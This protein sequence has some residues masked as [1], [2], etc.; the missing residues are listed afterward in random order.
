MKEMKPSDRISASHRYDALRWMTNQ[1]HPGETL[2]E[3][4]AWWQANEDK[5]QDEWIREGFEQAGLTLHSPLTKRDKKALLLMIGNREETPGY[6]WINAMRW[7]RDSDF[8]SREFTMSDL[9]GDDAD[10]ILMG[11]TSYSK[12][13][14]RYPKQW[15]PGV[16]DIGAPVL[17]G[18]LV[19]LSSPLTKAWFVAGVYSLIAITFGGGILCLRLAPRRVTP[20]TDVEADDSGG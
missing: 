19:I 6:R 5:T 7:L 3:W 16:L 12:F 9:A 17:D 11:L 14:G 18:G 15:S 8:D 13:E 4:L 10:L 2:R 1:D 20:Q